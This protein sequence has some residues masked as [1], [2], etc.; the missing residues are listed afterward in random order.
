MIM[1]ILIFVAVAFIVIWATSVLYERKIFSPRTTGEQYV[2]AMACGVIAALGWYFITTSDVNTAIVLAVLALAAMVALARHAG[3]IARIREI[4]LFLLAGGIFGLMLQAYVA[5]VLELTGGS[6]SWLIVPALISLAY[7]AWFVYNL[8]TYRYKLAQALGDE[9]G[10]GRW[11]VAGVI[12]AILL[13][14]SA[15]SSIGGFAGADKVAAIFGSN[16]KNTVTESVESLDYDEP[17][18]YEPVAPIWNYRHSQVLMDDDKANDYNFGPDP[19]DEIIADKVA[20]GKLTQAEADRAKTSKA[21]KALVTVDE[22]LNKFIDVLSADPAKLAADKFWLAKNHPSKFNGQFVTEKT[23]DAAMTTIDEAMMFYELDA[24]MF[25]EEYLDFINELMTADEI[26][27]EYKTDAVDQMYQRS[28]GADERPTVVVMTADKKDGVFITFKWYTKRNETV[29]YRVD[30]DFQP[31][32]VAKKLGVKATKNPNTVGGGGSTGSSSTTGGGGGPTTTGGGGSSTTGGGG[33]SGGGGTSGGGGNPNTDLKNTSRG[34]NVG[35]NDNTGAGTSTNNGQN[36]QYSSA[37]NQAS[38]SNRSS[39]ITYD[40]HIA[41]DKVAEKEE[42]N[43]TNK[44]TETKADVVNVDS[45]ANTGNGNGNVDT[46]SQVLTVTSGTEA[47]GARD[48]NVAN[49]TAGTADSW[50]GPPL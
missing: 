22:V 19:L 49:E 41:D 23:G 38:S 14:L 16:P 37:D 12:L 31:T 47:N 9:K 32:N 50:G 46:P 17:M 13:A 33:Y 35:G 44:P 6:I 4:W 8:V 30:C 28:S 40:K 36:A 11:K 2:E 43:T 20:S 15:I 45:K 48:N 1:S 3:E 29:S 5:R 10:A 39:M 21:K 27:L 18:D 7:T 34:T 24:E 25:N 42:K 26:L